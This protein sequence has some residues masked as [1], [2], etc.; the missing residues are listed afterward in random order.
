M[1]GFDEHAIFKTKK[2][3]T[4]IKF[5]NGKVS[6]IQRLD[7]EVSY[8]LLKKG[9]KY[10]IME[11]KELDPN[12]A[13]VIDV[14]EEPMLSPKISENT[15]EYK[16]VKLDDKIEKIRENPEDVIS[17][18]LNSRY[19][20]SGIVNIT[21]ST[22]S[23]STSKGFSGSDVRNSIDGYFRAFNGEFTGQ[24]AFASSSYS[25]S[26]IKESVNIAC[27]LAS[28]TKKAKVD[29]GVYNVVLSPL[30]FGNL[31]NYLA[32]MSS[33]LSIMM[34][35]S[36]FSR[37]KP[38]DRIASEK[39][40]FSDVP[41]TDMPNAVEFDMEATFTK[42]KKIIDHGVFKTPLLNNEV[43]EAMNLKSTGNAGWINPIP[44]TLEVDEGDVGK[45]S[46]LSGNV[47]FF[48][49]NWYTR[50]QNYV[51]G[52]FST[53]GRDA[54]IVYKNGNVEG[55]AGRLRIA[56]SL[57]NIIRNIEEISKERYLVKWWDSRI[58][59]LSPY[60]LVR[61]VKITRA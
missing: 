4:V 12:F 26:T 43:A 35:N 40:T 25:E 7:N 41:K 8:F 1:Q 36:I 5:V 17:L 20:I 2:E 6:T 21:R 9:N 50:F 33:G 46:L 60:V 30:V 39:F 56:D 59:V 38:E 31:M 28:I 10:I 58:P 47:I 45:D 32:R 15:G 34:G 52:N 3:V 22:I 14:M 27:E 16:F 42:N 18:V 23:L 49:N 48:N 29:D 57:I 55:V 51:E 11:G 44:W 61:D 54:V 19:P 37:Y 24:W 13:N 53:V